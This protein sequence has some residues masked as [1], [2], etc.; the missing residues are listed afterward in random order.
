[1]TLILYS[2]NWFGSGDISSFVFWTIPLSVGLAIKGETILNFFRTRPFWVRLLLIF[3]SSGLFSIGWVY[4][5][6]LILGGMI[7]A[8]SVPI[9]YLWIGGCVVQL[10]Y[11]DWHLPKQTEKQKISKVVLDLLAFPL[12]MIIAVIAIFIVSF[13]SSYLNRPE[14]ETYLIPS[15]FE[16]HFRIIY[17]EKCGINPI[18]EDGRRVLKIPDNGI[19]I[20]QPKFEAG[21][22]DHEYYLVDKNGKRK[23]A[24]TV[25]DFKQQTTKFPRVEFRGSGSLGGAMPDGGL[26]SESPLAIHFADFNLYNKD[27]NDQDEITDYKLK[28]Q[29]D[30]L[31]NVIVNKCRQ[32]QTDVLDHNK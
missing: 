7:N 23:K 28:Q 15:N 18:F 14:K 16:G 10:I 21:I 12:I 22:I 29:F 5:I 26:S 30:S 8:F 19:L 25:L 11:L 32:K 4:F 6:Y 20:I 27:I 13:L 17:G 2:Q 24:N 9:F 1:M 31:T 3:V